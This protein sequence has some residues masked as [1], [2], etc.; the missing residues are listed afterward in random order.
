MTS[1]TETSPS[2]TPFVAPAQ[3]PRLRDR[4]LVRQGLAT[5]LIAF[6]SSTAIS[7]WVLSAQW[8]SERMRIVQRAAQDLA[9]VQGAAAEAAFQLSPELA[10]RVTQALV[11]HETL[12]EATLSDNFGEVLSTAKNPAQSFGPKA[13]AAVL[14]GDITYFASDLNAR[15]IDGTTSAVG[16]LT[17]ALDPATL[18]RQFFERMQSVLILGAAQILIV[19]V[20]FAAVFHQ[21]ITKPLLG[22]TRAIAGIDPGHPGA[23]PIPM[24]RAHQA[25]E[26]G[27]L[28]Q[29][30][31]TLLERAQDN[32]DGR[33]EAEAQLSALARDL[34]HRVAKRTADLEKANRSIGDGIRYA[35]RLQGALLPPMTALDGAVRE[36]TVGWNPLDGVGGDLYWAGK[37]EGQGVIALM[38]CTGHGVPGAFMSAVASSV[39][40]RVLNHIGH[41]DPAKILSNINILMKSALHQDG[42]EGGYSN[43][44]LD[45]AVCVIDPA[46]RTLRFAGAGLSL[47]SVGATGH[48]QW[49]GDRFSLG[50]PDSRADFLFTSHE[51]A[52]GADQTFYLYTDGITDQ[53]GG[54][55]GRLIGK[56]RVHEIL[57]GNAG[58]G[59]EAQKDILFERLAEWRG[60]EHRRDDMTFLAFRPTV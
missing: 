18:A 43:D 37:F 60:D 20:L 55:H 1:S 56:R 38:D 47:F 53:V 27:I 44:G 8:Q 35:A 12:T 23:K 5:F 50:Y 2:V 16:K 10:S 26:L 34:E 41:D 39:L 54:P 22:L 9:L 11:G 24:P 4:L 58:L 17:I 31:N 13:L 40:N 42:G 59:L 46:T 57:E 25:D 33:D 21:L 51:I 30:L 45:A 32:L 36:W 3:P 52:Y 48:H 19:C 7:L 6:V 49:R 14:F 29:T 28:S 15:G